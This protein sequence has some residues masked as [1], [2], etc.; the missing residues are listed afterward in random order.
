VAQ[1]RAGASKAAHQQPDTQQ[2]RPDWQVADCPS[3]PGD[4][5]IFSIDVEEWFQVGAYEN[6]LERSSWPNLE[7]RVSNQLRKLL[8]LLAKYNSRATLFCLGSV[9]Q[10]QPDVLRHAR[11]AGHEIACHGWDHQRLSNLSFDQAVADIKRAKAQL[12]DITGAAVLGYRAPSFSLTAEHLP[13]Y[14]QIQEMGFR[15]S[16]SV[17][18]LRTDHYGM[19]DAPRQ[20]YWLGSKKQNILE[21]P[22]TTWS[23]LGRRWPAS[24]GGYFRLLPRGLGAYVFKAG[25]AQLGL[26][27]NF[28]THPW[29]IDPDQPDVKAAPLVA[30]FRHRVNQHNMMAKL[31]ALLAG[32]RFTTLWDGLAKPIYQ[33]AGRL[34]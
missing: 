6:V 4:V 31:D 22:M 10:K 19:P 11:D 34:W 26:P 32:A 28:Y 3:F 5:H 21:C 16:S 18:P 29:E 8:D 25:A 13:L 7:S 14:E 23:A 17:Y 30:R 24:G 20:P 9:A 27:G 1:I 2:I 15:Y 33:H 12:E